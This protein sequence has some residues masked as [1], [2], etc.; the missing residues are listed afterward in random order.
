MRVVHPLVGPGVRL[1]E[2]LGVAPEQVVLAHGSLGLAAAA[3]V[4]AP[5]PGWWLVAALL[6]Q[7]KTVLDNLDGALARST[8]RVSELGRYL[9]TGVDLLVNAALFAA[10]AAHGPWP[11]AL[12]AFAV[13]TV[14]LS[15]DFNAERLHR[16]AH[17]GPPPAR[18]APPSA[19]WERAALVLSRGLYR[20]VLAPQDAAVR[21]LELRLLALASGRPVGTA[22]PEEARLWWDVASTAALVNLGLSTQYVLLGACL[23]LGAPFAYA[24]LVLAQG[25][26]LLAVI[27][28]RVA[29]FRRRARLAAGAGGA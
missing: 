19:A 20:A 26:Y 23:A 3:L 14:L 28:W 25:A 27:G 22:T 17:G 5:T 7:V 9:D 16:E 2:R 21:S 18:G 12:L 29:K 6:L 1:L 24:W 4:A 15:Y 13:L 11:V 10:L 8:G